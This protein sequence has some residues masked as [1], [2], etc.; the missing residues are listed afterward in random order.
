[1][2]RAVRSPRL[3]ALAL[4]AACASPPPAVVPQSIEAPEPLAHTCGDVSR[5]TR[6][7]PAR[8]DAQALARLYLETCGLE[9]A[10]ELT[11]ALVR[12]PTVSARESPKDGPAFAAMATFLASWA[13]GAGLDFRAVGENDVWELGLG[14][15]APWVSFVMH[16]D[17]VPV[18]EGGAAAQDGL[19]PGWSHP[20]FEATLVGERLYGRGTEDDKGPIAAVL[21]ALHT[22][23]RFG[24]AVPGRISAIIGTAEEHDWSGMTRFAQ[25]EPH[26]R[27]VI[28]LDAGFPVVVAESG[29]VAW[30]LAAPR[31]GS[32]KDPRCIR[33]PEVHGGQFLTQVPGEARARFAPPRGATARLT[34]ELERAAAELGAARGARFAV[35]VEDRRSS[36]EVR[37][38]GNAVHSSVAEEGDNALWGLA[39][40]A[41]AL[42]LCDDGGGLMLRLLATRFDG[43]HHGERLGIAHAHPLMGPLLVAPTVLRTEADEVVLAINMRRPEG[44]DVEA[45]GRLLDGASARLRAELSP[46]LRER[47]ERHVGQP[48]VADT[49]GPLVATLLGIYRELSG[50]AEAAPISIR[51]GTYARL[52]PGAVSFGPALPGK[53]YRGHAPDEYIELDALRLTLRATLEATL[54]LA[55]AEGSKGP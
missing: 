20:P 29:F 48:A 22:L 16:G 37:V 3:A 43:D 1:M 40:L 50:D 5:F 55:A 47:G 25:S 4:L 23:A 38:T 12:F 24:V 21:V 7:A 36:V 30:R 33:V 49:R 46:R 32:G 6:A 39:A 51:G 9:E 41:S 42:P 31:E 13:Q 11:R 8:S 52:F 2:V 19:P 44:P 34:A 35:T 10:L 17:V 53:P 28:S 54:R 45:F 18:D 14:Q 27:H 15:G 26:A